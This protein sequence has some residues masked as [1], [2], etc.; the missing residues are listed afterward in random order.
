[1]TPSLEFFQVIEALKDSFLLGFSTLFFVFSAVAVL[2]GLWIFTMSPGVDD[3]KSSI[4]LI[5]VGILG[6]LVSAGLNWL[7][8]VLP[9]DEVPLTGHVLA[10]VGLYAVMFGASH[11]L[12][13]RVFRKGRT[14]FE[15]YAISK[16]DSVVFPRIVGVSASFFTLLGGSSAIIIGLFF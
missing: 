6:M 5:R 2:V 12:A 8:G 7:L 15:D 13:W 1:M 11:E 3:D 16:K 14:I 10:Q 9:P 4:P